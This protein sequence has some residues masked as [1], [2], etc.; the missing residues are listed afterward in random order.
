M[1]SDLAPPMIGLRDVALSENF[2]WLH[3][4]CEQTVKALPRLRRFAGSPELS[5]FAYVISNFSYGLTQIWAASWQN[6]QN[7]VHPAMTQIS[8]GICPVWSESSLSAWRKIGSS[9]TH[10]AHCEDSDQTWQMPRLIWVFAGCTCNF[11]GFVMPWHLFSAAT[12]PYRTVLSILSAACPGGGRVTPYI[13]YG[14]DMLLEQSLFFRLSI[15]Q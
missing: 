3:L 11:V 8:L 7:D 13:L 5:P 6:Q 10:W 15:H 14:T 9:A 2:L 12:T 1:V 4:L